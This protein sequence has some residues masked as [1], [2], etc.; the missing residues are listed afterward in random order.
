MHKSKFAAATAKKILLVLALELDPPPGTKQPRKE[1]LQRGFVEISVVDLVAVA[2]R[3]N[4]QQLGRL[5]I[6][7]Q[8]V[9][10]QLLVLLG[11]VEIV[12]RFAHVLLHNVC[13]EV[14]LTNLRFIVQ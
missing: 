5:P 2:R 6:R 14:Q 12:N 4:R 10:F 7:N 9:I 8:K 3:P 1:L 13:Q 11:A